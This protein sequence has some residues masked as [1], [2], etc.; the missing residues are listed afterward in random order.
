MQKAL[1]AKYVTTRFLKTVIQE[2]LFALMEK[3]LVAKSVTTPSLKTVSLNMN[4]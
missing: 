4:V 1:V 2:E 3:K